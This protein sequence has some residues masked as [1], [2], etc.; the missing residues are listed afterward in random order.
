MDLSSSS[1]EVSSSDEDQASNWNLLKEIWPVADR[2]LAL[3]DKN[4]VNKKDMDT[5]S[6]LFKMKAEKDKLDGASG[7][8]ANLA[9]DGDHP[10]VTFDKKKDNGRE[11]LHPARF[12]RYPMSE[13][14]K[15]YGRVPIKSKPIIR[16]LN[17]EYSGSQN[18]VSEKTI[19]FLHDRTKSLSLKH[20][21]SGNFS[22]S[23]KVQKEITVV[24]EGGFA[25][26]LDYDWDTPFNLQSLQEA[27]LN[28]VV[29]NHQ[30]YPYDTTGFS[31]MR[32][33]I[34]YRWMAH[35]ENASVKRN[36]IQAFFETVSRQNASRANHSKAPLSYCQQLDIFKEVL[37]KSGISP[38]VP[39]PV[40]PKNINTGGS[41]NISAS[42]SSYS[43]RSGKSTSKQPRKVA[44]YNN[45]FVCYSYNSTEGRIC[46]NS[47]TGVGCT[48]GKKTFAHVCNVWVSD[49]KDY[50]YKKHPRKDHV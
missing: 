32:I 15:W 21:Y 45:H 8:Y 47:M 37:L 27:L 41:N 20:F 4:T 48:D 25:K 33:L 31:M 16:Q 23:G 18:S 30:L 43:A 39:L 35:A 50:C 26:K 38:E 6:A 29:I 2:P 44:M 49:K 19:E 12:C 5:L 46:Q 14:N 24:E 40:I 17:L 22:V 13:P 36:I 11:K 1:E 28:F 3:Q 9:K 42:S 10:V 7:L 34:K